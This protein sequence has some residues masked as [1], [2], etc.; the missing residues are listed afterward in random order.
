MIS[1]APGTNTE[2]KLP[3][4]LRDLAEMTF[5]ENNFIIGS[6]LLPD[7]G[8][9]VIGGPPK[10]Y[11]S[12][13]ASTMLNHLV[14]GT[15]L[16]GAV[17]YPHGHD[18]NPEILFPI[19]RP[20]R[21]LYLEQEIGFQDVKERLLGGIDLMTPEHR[22]LLLD[23]FFVYSRD[24]EMQ[25]DKPEGVAKLDSLIAAVKPDVV[26]FDPLIE[27]HSS[28]E[29]DASEMNRVLKNLDFLRQRHHFA[30]IICHHTSKP[31][32]TSSRSGADLLRGSSVLYGKGDSFLIL[33]RRRGSRRS[34][35]QTQVDFTIRRGKPLESLILNLDMSDLRAK[36]T[37]ELA[38]HP[39]DSDDPL[40]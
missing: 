30:T 27:F 13:V 16:F 12:F 6:R 28:D 33:S 38:T 22:N 32:A 37:G 8:L 3:L 29:N 26:C 1:A 17:R 35:I 19:P 4:S 25:L 40:A 36:A 21:V 20:M 34:Q 39:E 31:S 2:P 11:K 24:I 18:R 5:P 23:N 14:T 15:P 9:M 7:N 10:S